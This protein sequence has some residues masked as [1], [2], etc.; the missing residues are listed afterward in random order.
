MPPGGCTIPAPALTPGALTSLPCL[1]CLWCYYLER[2]EAAW[3][4]LSKPGIVPVL[5]FSLPGLCPFCLTEPSSSI[6][7]TDQIEFQGLQPSKVV[8]SLELLSLP[9]LSHALSLHLSVAGLQAL[10]LSCSGPSDPTKSKSCPSWSRFRGLSVSSS[11]SPLSG[12]MIAPYGLCEIAPWGMLGVYW[13]NSFTSCAENL[14]HCVLCDL[15]FEESSG[16]SA[17]DAAILFLP[18]CCYSYLLG[19][20]WT[21][22]HL[23][24][25]GDHHFSEESKLIS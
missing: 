1:P 8:P 10:S 19:S 21:L 5:S 2:K 22:W 14:A 15:L 6:Y 9:G 4:T 17:R 20:S 12:T 24:V 25:Y 13:V 16:V 7:S 3:E 23:P 18:V 11:A